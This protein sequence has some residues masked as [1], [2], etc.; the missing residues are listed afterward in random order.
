VFNLV[1]QLF[2][3][4]WSETASLELSAYRDERGNG[5]G[6][7]VGSNRPGDSSYARRI[8]IGADLTLLGFRAALAPD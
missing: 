4:E 2:H 8:S 7:A 3:P 5:V 1:G 6:F